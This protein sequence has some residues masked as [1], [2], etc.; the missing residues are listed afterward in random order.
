MR[1]LFLDFDGVLNSGASVLAQG[2]SGSPASGTY[3]DEVSVELVARLTREM[4]LGVVFSTSWRARGAEGLAAVLAN[5][6]WFDVPVLGRTE[7][8]W[9]VDPKTSRGELIARWLY[10]NTS[11]WDGPGD[12]LVIDD[13]DIRGHSEKCVVQTSFS[14]GFRSQHFREAR[15]KLQAK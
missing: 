10:K 14:T 12:Y 8:R 7:L 11:G 4:D 5:Y 1:P 9:N 6:G 2:R 3:L 15:S 13:G